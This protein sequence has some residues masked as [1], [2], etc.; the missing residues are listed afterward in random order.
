[1]GKSRV[2]LIDYFIT[3]IIPLN[4][5]PR[6]SFIRA[7]D[8][9]F[10]KAVENCKTLTWPELYA[11][12]GLDYELIKKLPY[13]WGV[14]EFGRCLRKF[15]ENGERLNPL[16]LHLNHAN[17]YRQ[18]RYH[19]E[20]YGITAE[21]VYVKAGLNYKDYVRYKKYGTMESVRKGLIKIYEKNNYHIDVQLVRDLDS[22]LYTALM[23][24]GPTFWKSCCNVGF[25]YTREERPMQFTMKLR[26]KTII[27]QL[28]GRW[29]EVITQEIIDALKLRYIKNTDNINGSVPDFVHVKE[30]KWLEIKL[31]SK[32][33]NAALK[34]E[35]GYPGK[36]DKVIYMYLIKTEN[37]ITEIPDNVEIKDVLYFTN[38]IKNL[39]K[40]AYI[41][42][43]LNIIA[44]I[45][46]SIVLVNN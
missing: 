43:E 6:Q 10:Y 32:C 5:R 9:R 23:K 19:I 26:E 40:R 44:G 37:L 3:I 13:M 30:D 39:K 38:Q 8:H 29:L 20:K 14:D 7:I 16:S 15:Y 31:T 41:E 33:V 11:A 27:S 18:L 22:T 4:G 21:E 12:A 34:K 46:N 36:T 42:G 24:Y 45:H 25:T 1:M 17:F 28:F 35:D 2:E